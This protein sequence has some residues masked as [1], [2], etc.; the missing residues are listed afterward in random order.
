MKKINDMHDDVIF[1]IF[2]FLD[3]KSLKKAM[4]VCKK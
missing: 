1:E 3:A 2:E 4:Q